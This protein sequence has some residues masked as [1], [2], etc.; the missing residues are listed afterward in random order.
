MVIM[1]WNH[2]FGNDGEDFAYYGIQT[3]DG[4]YL[5]GGCTESYV[6]SLGE[7]PNDLWLIKTDE[8]GNEIWNKT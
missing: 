2:T 6:E 4:G 5:I 3:F 8:Y 7:V 1:L